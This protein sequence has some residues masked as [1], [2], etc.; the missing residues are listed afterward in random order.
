MAVMLPN[1]QVTA[2]VRS[3]EWVRDAHGTPVPS[4]QDD[5]SERGPFPCNLTEQSDKSFKCRLDPRMWPLRQGDEL[6]D[7]HGRVLTVGP[8]PIFHQVPGCSHVDFI[9]ATATPNDP[10]VL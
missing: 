3:H 4:A 10:P 7:E 6:E 8:D 1:A 9:E 5:V 2:R